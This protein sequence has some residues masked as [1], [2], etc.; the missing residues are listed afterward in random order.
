[1]YT[2]PAFAEDRTEMLTAMI[3]RYPLGMLSWSL[4][5]RIDATPLP[6][7]VIED[8]GAPVR[9]LAHLP[10]ANPLAQ[11]SGVHRGLISFTG[12]QAYISPGWY[13]TKREHGRVVPTWNYAVVLARGA[14]SVID[15]AVW[16]REQIRRLT[17]EQEAGRASPWS[18]DDAP[19]DYTAGLLKSLVGLEFSVSDLT[20]KWKVSQNQPPMN[21]E[22]V[23]AG[24]RETVVNAADQMARMVES[25]S[26]D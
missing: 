15:D 11:L 2:P 8:G 12:P 4:E 21:R 24:L 10:R 22:G 14:F 23:A 1:M 9:L 16:V 17:D 18:I 26:L 19:V 6:Y 3:R 13:P 25:A 7:L 20:G 5:G